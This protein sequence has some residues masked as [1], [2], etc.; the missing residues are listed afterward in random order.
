[1]VHYHF[2]KATHLRKPV[3]ESFSDF[4]IFRKSQQYQIDSDGDPILRARPTWISADE[5][6]DMIQNEILLE[7]DANSPKYSI[8]RSVRRDIE[9]KLKAVSAEHCNIY[10][11]KDSGWVITEKDN[12]R[13]SSNGT[14][15]FMKSY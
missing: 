15:V 5:N 11:D 3:R 13:P 1:M 6:K 8:G 7:Y 10:Y 4:Q 12:S 14:F 2:D 9:I